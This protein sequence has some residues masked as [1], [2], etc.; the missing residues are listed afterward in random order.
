MPVM[1]DFEFRRVLNFLN[2]NEP[3]FKRREK[4]IAFDLAFDERE[5]KVGT[6]RQYLLVNLSAAADKHISLKIVWV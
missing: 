6:T 1:Q 5:V 4:Y 2:L 3:V